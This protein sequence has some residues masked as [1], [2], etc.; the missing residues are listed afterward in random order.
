MH[1][2]L[3]L[4]IVK[5]LAVGALAMVA[6]AVQADEFEVNAGRSRVVFDRLAG[7]PVQWT[8][9]ESD[10]SSQDVRSA[11]LFARGDGLFNVLSRF[12]PGGNFGAVVEAGEGSTRIV[13]QAV[14][15]TRV[16][17]IA[18]DKASMQVELLPGTSLQLATGQNFIPGQ[19]PGFGQLYS[20]VHAVTVSDD[21]QQIYADSDAPA[22]DIEVDGGQWAGI[23]NRYWTWLVRPVGAGLSGQISF[24]ELDRPHLDLQPVDPSLPVV[25]E[26]Y[27]GAVEWRELREVSPVLSEMLFA[28]LWD[29]LRWLCFGMLLLLEFLQNLVGSF[30]VAIILLSLS[31]KILMV[32]LTAIA[33]RWQADVNRINTLMEP[34]LTAIKR[35]Y[36]GEDAHRRILG[37]YKKH[38]V[39]QWYTFKSAAGFLIQ[40]PVFIAA[41]DMLAENFALNQIGFLW[42]SDLAAPDQLAALPFV[43]PFFGGW[44][45]LLPFLMTGLSVLAAWLQNE[46]SLSPEL[47]R[48][49][50]IRLYLMSAVF[51]LAF[52]T[53][54]AGMVL[55]WTSSNLF[56]LLKVELGSLF[57]RFQQA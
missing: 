40:I 8:V 35:D 21:G 50:S 55:Y 24:S 22:V 41:F 20:R 45:N 37:V 49:Q 32:P 39:S 51:F 46:D 48:Q 56:H 19:L 9:C 25:V 29:F 57:K 31:V 30:G 7:V 42:M 14:T 23:R 12:G 13:F 52:Y 26:I 54:P 6:C 4:K 1:G 17:R 16:Y 43:F 11:E 3:M 2:A 44:L 5:N 34:E 33:D 10:C 27:A 47:Q 38:N 53:F 28:A 18:H 36:K 15:E